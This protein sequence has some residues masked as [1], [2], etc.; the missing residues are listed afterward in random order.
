METLGWVA[1]A[2]GV[3]SLLRTVAALPAFRSWLRR[4]RVRDFTAG[5]TPPISIRT[6]GP[7]NAFLRQNYPDYEVIAD[8]PADTDVPVHVGGEPRHEILLLANPALRPDP[9]FLRDVA[10]GGRVAF[11]PVVCGAKSVR[12]RL[13]ALAANTDAMLN[14]LLFGAGFARGAACTAA[15]PHRIARRPVRVDESGLAW[16]DLRSPLSFVLACAAPLLAVCIPTRP[17]A[18]TLLILIALFRIGFAVSMELRFTKDGTTLGAL[19]WLPLAWV[20]EPV[21]LLGRRRSATLPGR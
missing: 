13:L 19:V 6:A 3:A 8:S 16:A 20:M 10:D 17:G 5:E 18:L 12:G 9:L 4:G 11:I 7:P 2:L 21:L 15:G 1:L 14:A